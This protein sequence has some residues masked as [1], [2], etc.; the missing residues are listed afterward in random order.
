M[1]DK[2]NPK[3]TSYVRSGAGP[4]PEELVTWGEVPPHYP[5]AWLGREPE[6]DEVYLAHY[7]ESDYS[8]YHDWPFRVEGA[9]FH[10]RA[11][12]YEF[13]W[14]LSKNQRQRLVWIQTPNGF[15]Q[16]SSW[17][18][19][20][21]MQRDGEWNEQGRAQKQ[22]AYDLRHGVDQP[23]PTLGDLVPEPS[24]AEANGRVRAVWDPRLKK[25]VVTQETLEPDSPNRARAK[26]QAERLLKKASDSDPR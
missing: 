19:E 23:V 1:S 7:T 6:G 12:C 13:A 25:T 4:S 9:V 17:W 10:N 26:K 8:C 24:R 2:A 18:D 20:E 15:P 14:S 22:A 16:E 21:R 3:S 11:D 5:E